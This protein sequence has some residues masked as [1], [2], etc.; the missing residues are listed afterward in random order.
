MCSS[1]LKISCSGAIS[2]EMLPPKLLLNRKDGMFWDHLTPTAE[3]CWFSTSK[4]Q[5][6]VG[7]L[8]RMVGNNSECFRSQEGDEIKRE[9]CVQFVS[10]LTEG[11]RTV[12]RHLQDVKPTK[13]EKDWFRVE[14]RL[15]LGAVGSERKCSLN[16]LEF[17][18]FCSRHS[19]YVTFVLKTSS[20]QKYLGF[21]RTTGDNSSSS[22]AIV[23]V[24]K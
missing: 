11:T 17:N 1:S 10:S 15:L 21:Y 13:S 23:V 22:V 14:Q 20:F 18:A 12:H 4:Y 16:C 6:S 24:C 2:N 5:M 3:R 7:K 9:Q 19:C 8:Q